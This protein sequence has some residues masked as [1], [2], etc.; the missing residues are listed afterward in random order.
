[1]QTQVAEQFTKFYYDTFDRNR[2]DLA[3][4]YVSSTVP[5]AKLQMT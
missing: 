4:L 3:P 2:A 1:M 5:Y